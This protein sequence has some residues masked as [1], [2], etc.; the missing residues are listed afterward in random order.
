MEFIGRKDLQVK[1]RGQRVELEEVEC[2]I[3][4]LLPR[5]KQVAVDVSQ[6]EAGGVSLVAYLCFNR[7]TSLVGRNSE[8][9]TTNS[10]GLNE[11]NGFD[12]LNSTDDIFLPL[13]PQ[14]EKE[15][16]NLITELRK[17]LPSYMVPATFIPCHYMPFITTTKLDRNKLRRK[18]AE[19]DREE[20]ARYSLVE[21]EKKQPPKTKEEALMQ[22][23]WASVLKLPAE[24]IGRKDSFL[25]IGGDSIT[26]IR[27]VLL[28]RSQGLNLSVPDIFQNGQ[29]LHL[30]AKSGAVE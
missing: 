8:Q 30:A 25:Q 20:I 12:T 17:K 4:T 1:I 7:E 9:P 16:R 3:Q 11:G 5:V 24:M 10:I 29:L 21:C 19:L 14:M 28:A 22:Q 2:N 6:T 18:T 13:T 27:L 15:V 23:L 26:A